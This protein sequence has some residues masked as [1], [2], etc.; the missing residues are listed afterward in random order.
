VPAGAEKLLDILAVPKGARDFTH[1]GKAGRL[2]A[3]TSLPA[4]SPVFP[5]YIEAEEKAS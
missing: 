5:R 2:K 4:P 1:L 3:G